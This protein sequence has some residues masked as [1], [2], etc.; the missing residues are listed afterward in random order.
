[1][2][3]SL[4]AVMVFAF[5]AIGATAMQ[6]IATQSNYEA[7]Q[8]TQA[9]YVATDMIERIRNNPTVVDSYDNSADNQWTIVGGDTI[10]TEPT[11]DCDTS[12]C[13]PQ[14]QAAHDLW[15]LEQ[16]LDGNDTTQ[17]TLGAIGG[18]QDPTGCIRHTGDGRVELAVAWHG[19]RSMSNA[20]AA[21][22]CT[23]DDDRYG[24]NSEFRRVLQLRTY[25]A[26]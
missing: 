12:A 16:A 10:A 21:P 19:R 5:G 24:P 13:T 3:E 26:P 14:Q 23:G 1:M 11:P 20:L 17:A 25:I 6:V 22:G 2:L 8:R 7:S 15:R 18:L 4:V 9:V